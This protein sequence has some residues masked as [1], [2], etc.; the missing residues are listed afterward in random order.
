TPR[1]SAPAM[2]FL[3]PL[4]TKT[5]PQ[6]LG[7]GVEKLLTRSRRMIDAEVLLRVAPCRRCEAE[8]TAIADDRVAHVLPGAAQA[9]DGLQLIRLADFRVEHD[10]GCG[11]DLDGFVASGDRAG[12][13]P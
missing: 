5:P 8:R 13:R 4:Q 1:R 7:R 2:V 10:F 9:G 3:K 12:V 11:V 6:I